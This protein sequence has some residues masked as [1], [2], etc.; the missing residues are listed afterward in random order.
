MHKDRTIA[1][2]TGLHNR[3]YLERYRYFIFEWYRSVHIHL[4]SNKR[5]N[6]ECKCLE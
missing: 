3:K 1:P 2:V 4:S 6:F 5:K